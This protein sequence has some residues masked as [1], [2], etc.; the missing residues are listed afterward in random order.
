MGIPFIGSLLAKYRGRGIQAP[1][2]TSKAISTPSHNTV[3][4]NRGP[5][6]KNYIKDNDL[7]KAQLRAALAQQA[8]YTR[9]RRLLPW[10]VGGTLLG[11]AATTTSILML[12][13]KLVNPDFISDRAAQAV[14]KTVDKSSEQLG[15][16]TTKAK[17][18]GQKYLQNKFPEV[19]DKV[20]QQAKKRALDRTQRVHDT[21]PSIPNIPR[22][23][24]PK[25]SP[26]YNSPANVQPSGNAPHGSAYN[27]GD[28][29]PYFVPQNYK[30][31]YQQV[32][33][34]NYQPLIPFTYPAVPWVLKQLSKP[35]K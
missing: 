10:Q 20:Q 21:L 11:G 22:Q 19:L 24:P 7:R 32:K 8:Y 33:G 14:V 28:Y 3:R 4:R 17:G 27:T 6:S 26:G 16:R 23:Q 35:H 18:I 29:M 9:R 30:N 1:V 34:G 2:I 25:Q 13:H 5:T 15:D 31:I 12:L